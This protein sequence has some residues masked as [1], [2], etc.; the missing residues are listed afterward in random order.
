MLLFNFF[1]VFFNSFSKLK[2]KEG[3]ENSLLRIQT[4][5]WKPALGLFARNKLYYLISAPKTWKAVS[6][7]AQQFAP[8]EPFSSAHLSS[9]V[10]FLLDHLIF[11]SP[12]DYD[13]LEDEQ[14]KCSTLLDI[15]ILL[16]LF[17]LGMRKELMMSQLL[18]LC[19]IFS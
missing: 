4:L 11:F 13:V 8:G 10:S 3:W 1:P 9:W 19:E 18:R 17:L 6:S 2:T 15:L 7:S 12:I 14:N 16:F 5:H